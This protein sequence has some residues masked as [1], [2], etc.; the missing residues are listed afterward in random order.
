MNAARSPALVLN[1]TRMASVTGE[2]LAPE[3]GQPGYT[4]LEC[5][6]SEPRPD[7]LS[8]E[9]EPMRLGTREQTVDFDNRGARGA[10][11]AVIFYIP[12]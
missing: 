1:Y 2:R 12:K 5:A 6:P 10:G 7:P 9:G 4:V 11:P 8:G 3:I